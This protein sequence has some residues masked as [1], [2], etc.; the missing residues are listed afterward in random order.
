MSE[1]FLGYV[2]ERKQNANPAS[3]DHALI[4]IIARKETGIFKKLTDE[5]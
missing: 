1:R 3:P 5:Q 4:K 2:L